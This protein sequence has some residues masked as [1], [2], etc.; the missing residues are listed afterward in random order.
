MKKMA[1]KYVE[2]GGIDPTSNK[3]PEFNISMNKMLDIQV[4][5]YYLCNF[6]TTPK[7]DS[8]DEATDFRQGL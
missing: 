6:F 7:E 5:Y 2:F 3:K 4:F 1:N 8:H